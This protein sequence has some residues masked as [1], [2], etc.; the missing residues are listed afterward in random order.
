MFK[1]P[2]NSMF[3]LNNQRTNEDRWH[4]PEHVVS[5]RALFTFMLLN[6][7]RPLHH[8]YIQHTFWGVPSNNGKYALSKSNMYW[9]KGEFKANWLSAQVIYQPSDFW[10]SVK[11][12]TYTHCEQK[13]QIQ[14]HYLLIYCYLNKLHFKKSNE[15]IIL[16]SLVN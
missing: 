1:E 10:K 2:K 7:L 13:E 12:L 9:N 14:K 8:G 4:T 15:N 11:K 6:Y 5:C 3:H 16:G